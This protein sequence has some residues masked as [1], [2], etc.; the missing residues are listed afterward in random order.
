[1]VSPGFRPPEFRPDLAERMAIRRN[2][3]SRSLSKKIAG[4]KGRIF[5]KPR[6]TA[7]NAT[8]MN[9]VTAS[10]KRAVERVTPEPGKVAPK[11]RTAC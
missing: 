1:M 5:R 10:P 8:I 7:S 3:R 11:A 6:K 4:V 9:V 2:R